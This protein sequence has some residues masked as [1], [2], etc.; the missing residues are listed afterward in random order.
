MLTMFFSPCNK[1]KTF[2]NNNQNVLNKIRF[3]VLINS[4][5]WVLYSSNMSELSLHPTY[6][7]KLGQYTVYRGIYRSQLI[8]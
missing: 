3:V 6:V 8:D 7:T 1:T 5:L 2:A 4:F